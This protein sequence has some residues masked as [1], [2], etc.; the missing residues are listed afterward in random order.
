MFEFLSSANKFTVETQIDYFER[1]LR[2]AKSR[3]AYYPEHDSL[4]VDAAPKS[5]L[6][7]PSEE[8]ISKAREW[9]SLQRKEYPDSKDILALCNRWE[10][11]FEE[12]RK[13]MEVERSKIQSDAAAARK[14]MRQE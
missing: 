11:L 14:D 9:I 3:D 2:E 7:R 13:K 5:A 12:Y 6:G 10:R 8:S 1:A 4:S